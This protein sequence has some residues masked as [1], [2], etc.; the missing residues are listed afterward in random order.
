MHRQRL[1]LN[2]VG[3]EDFTDRLT[4]LNYQCAPFLNHAAFLRSIAV[5]CPN[6][7]STKFASD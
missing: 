7:F 3:L 2:T 5:S 6:T 1:N 4:L